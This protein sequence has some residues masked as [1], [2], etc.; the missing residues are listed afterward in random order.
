MKNDSALSQRW[1]RAAVER[2]VLSW[3]LAPLTAVYA[4]LWWLRKLW[5][6][7]P[8]SRPQRVPVPVLVVGNVVV[9]G[10]G[11]TPTTLAILH[12]LRQAGWRPGVVSRGYGRE[13]RDTLE[14]TPDTEARLSGDEPLLICQQAGVPVVVGINRSD[15]ARRL[16]QRHPGVDLIVCDDGL[17]HWG[18]HRDL[19]IVVFDSRGIGNGWLLPSGLLREP[20]PVRHRFAPHLVLQHSDGSAVCATPASD[21]PTYMAQRRLSNTC[22]NA[23][24]HTQALANWV[25]RSFSVVTGIAQPERFVA[26]LHKAGVR[27]AH[28]RALPDHA[29]TA[30]W[31]EAL[32][33]V[34][35]PVLCTEK[36]M[37]KLRQALAPED[38]TRVW[39]VPLELQLD[40]AFLQTIEQRL[41]ATAQV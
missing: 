13:G 38:A 34:G 8:W 31:Q 21:L 28:W 20:W 23:A 3:A 1:R 5:W 18:L 22:H 4:L 2:G 40:P 12:H 32:R 6:L 11:K 19:A 36:D 17:Q 41:K 26:M 27:P 33:A 37:V 35:G 9:G 15:A 24:G 10:A 7:G 25:T 29:S 14:V 16:L 39:A 30:T